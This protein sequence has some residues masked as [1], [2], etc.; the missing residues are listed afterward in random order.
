MNCVVTLSTHV[1]DDL[2][3]EIVTIKRRALLAPYS[4]TVISGRLAA[5]LGIEC[6]GIVDVENMTFQERCQLALPSK[7]MTLSHPAVP[8][9]SLEIAPLINMHGA[10]Y[11][12]ILGG[13]WVHGL[14]GKALEELSRRGGAGS[15]SEPEPTAS[16]GPGFDPSVTFMGHNISV[17]EAVAA[18]L[19]ALPSASSGG[20]RTV[21]TSALLVARKAGDTLDVHSVPAT[22][23][24][25]AHKMR[26]V[27]NTCTPATTTIGSWERH[28][29]G[30]GLKL[31]QKHGF[32]GRLG[33]SESGIATPIKAQ[34]RPPRV[35]L[36][37]APG[38][39]SE[40][41][42]SIAVHV[43]PAEGHFL[44]QFS[45]ATR[46]NPGIAAGA[47]ILWQWMPHSGETEQVWT[48]DSHFGH[49]RTNNEADYRALLIGLD[50]CMRRQL[51]L[52]MTSCA[53]S[54]QGNSE[55]V[56]RQLEGAYKVKKEELRAHHSAATELIAQLRQWCKV[57]LEWIPREQNKAAF[58]LAT[59]C[60]V[61]GDPAATSACR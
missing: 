49:G 19:E 35:G 40:A 32:N 43:P 59:E 33:A 56:M 21:H 2:G 51:G 34:M 52:G 18:Q 7:H 1:V 28:T 6:S 61:G 53:L 22:A 54:L 46:G 27:E 11:D 39:N 14:V 13:P 58:R 30:M 48:G 38:E 44:L 23:G 9:G 20:R 4:K 47:A 8:D 57:E 42:H 31:L 16:P 17:S 55:L 26:K 15:S 36:G 3:E 24:C 60:L 41:H 45:G 12:L 50:E 25:R 37:C 29:K 10:Y 5:K